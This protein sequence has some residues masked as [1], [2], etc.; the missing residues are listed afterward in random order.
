MRPYAALLGLLLLCA[1]DSESTGDGG[2]ADADGGEAAAPLRWALSAGGAEYDFAAGAAARSGGTCAIAGAF[3]GSSRFGGRELQSA[4]DWD[5]FLALYDGDGGLDWALGIGGPG[6]ERVWA[7]DMLPDGSVLCAGAFS[8]EMVLGKGEAGET[9]LV[10]TGAADAFAARYS[11]QGSLVWARSAGSSASAWARAAAASADGGCVL[12]GWFAGRLTLGAGTPAET[13][14][15]ASGQGD[16]FV[17]RLDAGGALLWARRIGGP[18]DVECRAVAAAPD[19]GLVALG[20]FTG[21]LEP[22]GGPALQSAGERDL[23]LAR[24]GPQGQLGWIA[25]IGGPDFDEPGSVAVLADGSVLAAGSFRQ[26]CALAGA[27]EL[28]S[29]GDWDV[30]AARFAPDGGLVWARR[31][32]G[33][34][35]EHAHVLRAV[36]S[37]G[38][39]LLTGWFMGPAVL[40]PGDPGEVTLQPTCSADAFLARYDEDG[41]LEWARQSQGS[42]MVSGRGL[43]ALED[44]SAFWMGGFTNSVTFGAGTQGAVTLSAAGEQD[45]FLAR[46]GP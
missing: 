45:V 39:F 21:Q 2:L 22:D 44:G 34:R 46:V 28:V 38:G 27:A 18:G 3:Q 30:F 31:A 17:A 8:G 19:G 41:R 43:A 9:R 20:R 10:A 16:A 36:D 35:G 42:D 33:S 1:C 24:F 4:G 15:E 37:R 14:L 12:G 23:F 11:A 25:P 7:V 32:G 5:G 6:Y 29:A 40:G 13:S 26:R